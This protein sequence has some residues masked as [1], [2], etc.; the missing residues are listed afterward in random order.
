MWNN[1]AQHAGDNDNKL[2]ASETFAVTFDASSSLAG[3][4]LPVN[5]LSAS[6]V[7]YTNPDGSGA[8][9]PLP[10]AYINVQGPPVAADDAASTLED[11]PVDIAVLANDSD[12]NGDTLT[13]L[14]MENTTS[15]GTVSVSVPPKPWTVSVTWVFSGEPVPCRNM[16]AGLAV[17]VTI[18]SLAADAGAVADTAA[19][20]NVPIT[21]IARN[22]SIV[23]MA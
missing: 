15:I 18:T 20:S 2:L 14:S 6:S 4:N 1:I 23:L 17:F 9:V 10:Q 16:S 21:A 11:T 22:C 8:S 19:K 7:D 3:D 13:E 5:D 12:P